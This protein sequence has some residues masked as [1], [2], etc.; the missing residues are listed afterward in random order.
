MLSG[1]RSSCGPRRVLANCTSS[2]QAEQC[3]ATSSTYTA[4]P[5]R[6]VQDKREG[7]GEGALVV[8]FAVLVL[9]NR[10]IEQAGALDLVG[11][12]AALRAC[13]PCRR[14]QLRTNITGLQ[15]M[16]HVSCPI[17]DS[18]GLSLHQAI[19]VAGL[20]HAQCC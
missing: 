14:I 15:A 9:G 17:G 18:C 20:W 12:K 2:L 8:G 3:S 7:D 6:V 4:K 10:G 19:A 16:Q 11:S 13:R 1:M 5:G